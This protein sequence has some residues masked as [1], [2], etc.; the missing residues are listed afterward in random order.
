MGFWSDFGKGVSSHFTAISFIAKHNL[1]VYF[2]FPICITVG[3]SLL[4]I[5]AISEIAYHWIHSLSKSI[6][7]YTQSESI[8]GEILSVIVSILNFIAGTVVKWVLTFFFFRILRYIVLIICSPI[9]TALSKRVD[10]IHTG[11][12]IPFNFGQFLHDMFRA[13]LVVIRN[14]LLETL[15]LLGI[16]SI[17]WIPV[18]GWFSIPFYWIIGWYFIGFNMMDYTYERRKLRISQGAQFTRKHKGIA[19]GNGMIYTFL[20]WIPFLGIC[21]APILSSVAA[22]LAT[23]ET[24]EKK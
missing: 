17:C 14:I 18:I 9:M 16:L 23:M 13:I 1:W 8:W 7:P 10:E 6:E 24:M 20:L 2:I 12:K 22:T 3:L 11:I 19:I 15:C 5:Y 4:G 21:F